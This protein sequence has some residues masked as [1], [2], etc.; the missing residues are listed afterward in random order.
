M[1]TIKKFDFSGDLMR[2]TFEEPQKDTAGNDFTAATSWTFADP[3]QAEKH[4][5]QFIPD[6]KPADIAKLDAVKA[7]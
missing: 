5:A 2:V 1:A 3:M 6:M 4:R 7:K